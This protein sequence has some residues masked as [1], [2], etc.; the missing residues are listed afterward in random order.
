MTKAYTIH[1][2]MAASSTL[3]VDQEVMDALIERLSNRTGV[4]TEAPTADDLL[5]AVVEMIPQPV[6]GPPLFT[7]TPAERAA[8]M[9][10]L[11]R[12]Y[13]MCTQDEVENA[14]GD[15][16]ADLLHWADHRPDGE[17]PDLD[18]LIARAVNNHDAEVSEH[19]EEL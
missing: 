16:I 12:I 10:F 14:A 5:Q 13:M 15:M 3:D 17:Q 2:L 8:R 4:P 11:V 9:D 19:M 18:T 1:D 7:S 6:M